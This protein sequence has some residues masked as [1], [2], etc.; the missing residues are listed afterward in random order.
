MHTYKA[1]LFLASALVSIQSFAESSSEI[2]LKALSSGRSSGILTGVDAEKVSSQTKSAEPVN[3]EVKIVKKYKQ[4]GC[5][6]L[7]YKLNQE[8]A[9]LNNGGTAPFEAV[10]QLNLC[11]DGK[12]PKALN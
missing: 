9:L 4:P 10:W 2:S 7:E 1:I 5:A 8:K 11:E 12:P 3:L 6:K